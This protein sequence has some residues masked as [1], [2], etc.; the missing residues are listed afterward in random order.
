[1][2]VKDPETGY[3]GHF[4]RS[5]DV[6]VTVIYT[7]KTQPSPRYTPAVAAVG[8]DRDVVPSPYFVRCSGTNPRSFGHHQQQQQ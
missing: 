3:E 1:M 5:I 4:L 7:L 2:T 8:V 6:L